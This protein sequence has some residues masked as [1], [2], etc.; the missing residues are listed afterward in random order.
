[1]FVCL[2][3]KFPDAP[4]GRKLKDD[5]KEKV[6][7]TT[8]LIFHCSQIDLPFIIDYFLRSDSTVG[9]ACHDCPVFRAPPD[10]RL[11]G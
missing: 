7:S 6:Y 4:C 11:K 1:M 3:P 10:H 5:Y 9:G 2:L 8:H